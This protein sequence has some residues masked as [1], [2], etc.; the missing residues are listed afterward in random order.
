MSYNSKEEYE[1][2]I[3]SFK[4]VICLIPK[5]T[6][7]VPSLDPRFTIASNLNIHTFVSQTLSSIHD[8]CQKAFTFQRCCNQQ[9]CSKW[10]TAILECLS[11]DIKTEF[12]GKEIQANHFPSSQQ[13]SPKTNDNCKE[14]HHRGWENLLS[15]SKSFLVNHD[16]RILLE[17]NYLNCNR[18][19]LP[20]G[21][22]TAKILKNVGND[23]IH[24]T[25]KINFISNDINQNV[26]QANNNGSVLYAFVS[27]NCVFNKLLL[28]NKKKLSLNFVN[29][30]RNNSSNNNLKTLKIFGDA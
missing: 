3:V 30:L 9:E 20:I 22:Q 16:G 4:D 24:T 14:T 23:V 13:K 6:V 29:F 18:A 27:R 21:N 15:G 25:K 8:P 11:R 5:S 17:L 1:K 12:T 7:L 28:F 2:K 10:I 19:K 26:G